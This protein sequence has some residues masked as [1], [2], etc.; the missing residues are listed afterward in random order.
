VT[1]VVGALLAL[2]ALTGCTGD[3]E[4]TTESTASTSASP[5]A[6]P[7]PVVPSPPPA[8]PHQACYLLDYDDALADS[9]TADPLRC[10]EPHTAVTFFVGRLVDPDPGAAQ[11][12]VAEQCPRRLASFIGGTTEDRRLTM[13]RPI[14]FTPTPEESDAGARWFRCDVVAVAADGKLAEL[15]AGIAGALDR[16]HGRDQY[17]MCGTAEPGTPQFDRVVCS[18]SHTWRAIQVVAFSGTKYPGEA[19][20]RAAGE[21]PCQDAGATV[22][23]DA[24]DYRWGYEWPTAEQWDA[25]QRFGRCWAPD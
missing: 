18:R 19:Q 15:T 2:L 21:T 4:T 11:A 24:L 23:D 3:D 8:G 16:P 22:A 14:W 6:T 9:S 10:R 5:T 1:R 17:G 20:V 7:T 13:L 12:Q 25:G